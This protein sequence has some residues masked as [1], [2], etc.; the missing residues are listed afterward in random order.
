MKISMDG[1]FIDA[2]RDSSGKIAISIGC[3]HYNSD[4][5]R[6]DTVINTASITDDE[7]VKLFSNVFSNANDKIETIEEPV[8]KSL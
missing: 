6:K 8:P 3:E 7:I 4:G 5:T 1:G 2:T